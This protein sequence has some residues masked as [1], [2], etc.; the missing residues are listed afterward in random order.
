MIWALHQL[1]V[2]K[3]SGALPAS[4]AKHTPDFDV[5]ERKRTKKAEIFEENIP[6]DLRF[7]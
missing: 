4:T 5:C 1:D 3:S 6:T 7:P 2:L